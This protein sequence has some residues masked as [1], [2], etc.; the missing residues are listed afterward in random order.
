[1]KDYYKIL[2]LERSAADDDIK[3]AYRRLASQYHP[4]KGGDTERF[5]EIQEAYS[6]L[7]D[8]AQRQQYD[9]PGIRIN[10]GSGHGFDFDGIFN[11]FG[12]RFQDRMSPTSVSRLQLWISLRDVAQ[13]GRRPV[14]ISSRGG[15]SN[16]E[17]DIPQG[18][19]DGSSIRYPK[20]APGGNDLVVTFRI[21][22]EPG[23]ERQDQNVIRDTPISIWDL[24]TGGELIV[25]TL[26]GS[27]ISLTIPPNTQPGTMMRIKGHGL[28]MFRYPTSGDMLVRLI[29]RLPD[30]IS[31]EL[32]DMIKQEKSR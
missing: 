1:V 8:P 19:E 16:I 14:A 18:V 32:R 20:L 3:R 5:Q 13:G 21:N 4:D 26:T 11:M 25:T 6:V 2:G 29:A 23:W 31:L 22:P 30:Q 10:M 17:I 9:N 7:S 15:Q 27:N 24:I 12:A 28:K